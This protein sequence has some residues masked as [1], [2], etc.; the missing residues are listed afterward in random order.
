MDS[1]NQE[2]GIPESGIVEIETVDRR[3]I[4]CSNVQ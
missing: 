4:H 1:E 2:C 3:K